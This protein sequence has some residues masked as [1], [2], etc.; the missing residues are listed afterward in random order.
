MV[1]LLSDALNGH[2]LKRTPAFPEDPML[3]EI[4]ASDVWDVKYFRSYFRKV[5]QRG[6]LAPHFYPVYKGDHHEVFKWT[7]SRA[8]SRLWHEPVSVVLPNDA[9]IVYRKISKW[10]WRDF[11]AALDDNDTSRER[12]ASDGGKC[13]SDLE[14]VVT[15][16][17]G[18]AKGVTGMYI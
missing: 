10:N 9:P 12:N 3:K 1:C 15:G 14:I 5:E 2:V 18:D 17:N 8:E 16:L 6:F 7:R 11:I 13:M 4:S